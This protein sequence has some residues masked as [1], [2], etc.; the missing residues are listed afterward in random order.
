VLEIA[1]DRSCSLITNT[2]KNE[3]NEK[4]QNNANE[5][6]LQLLPDLLYHNNGLDCTGN[7]PQLSWLISSISPAISQS[8]FKSN[9]L[10]QI[11]NRLSSPVYTT[12][13]RDI[14]P[15][16]R[17]LGTGDWEGG[18]VLTQSTYSLHTKIYKEIIDFPLLSS[19]K[20]LSYFLLYKS[21]W[22]NNMEINKQNITSIDTK[23]CEN[24][25]TSDSFWCMRYDPLSVIQN[26]KNDLLNFIG[27]DMFVLLAGSL[28]GGMNI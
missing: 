4:I 22:N 16:L 21:F 26:E 13:Y 12:N 15:G 2:K 8:Y 3:K 14:P 28:K 20:V 25:K 1:H 18:K 7:T 27:R 23:L 5:K 11:I 17:G 9:S 10:I 24:L 6:I 19:H